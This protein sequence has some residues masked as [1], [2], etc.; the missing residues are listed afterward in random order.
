MEATNPQHS[1]SAKTL[2]SMSNDRDNPEPVDDLRPFQIQLADRMK[3]L[4]AYLFARLNQLMYQKRRA[5]DDVIDMGMGNPSDPPADFIIEKLAE[6]ARDPKNHGYSPVVGIPNLRREVASRYLKKWGVRLD[7]DSEVIVTLGSKEGFSHLC[8]ALI[9]PGDTA[10]VPAPTYPAHMY[11]V[12]LAA[13][14][15]ITLEVADSEKFLVEHRIRLPAHSAAAESRDFELSAQPIDRDRRAGVLRRG[16]EVGTALLVHFDQRFG[17]RRCLLRRLSGT[18]PAL[19]SWRERCGSR[20]HDDEQRLQHGR[21]ADRLLCWQRGN[22]PGAGHDQSLL[23]LRH[24]PADANRRDHGA[25]ARRI[26]SRSTS[27]RIPASPRC[28]V[29]WTATHRLGHHAAAGQHV[30][31]D[32]N[33]S[34]RGQRWARSISR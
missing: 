12:T 20:I 6:A 17:V 30:P 29:R 1:S 8:L 13:G 11:G 10:I 21:L 19:N 26:G 23:R 25:A 5:G 16:S 24:V 27:Q 7:P 3:R 32:E 14:N 9:G 34:S 22:C 18:E 2:V 31:V 4:P 28:F 15:A 33:P